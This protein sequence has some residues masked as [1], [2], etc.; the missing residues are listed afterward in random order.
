M[1]ELLPI[2][3]F[4]LLY[5]STKYFNWLFENVCAQEYAKHITFESYALKLVGVPF[6]KTIHI[7]D[8]VPA[9][10]FAIL[11]TTPPT[12]LLLLYVKQVAIGFFVMIYVMQVSRS[13]ASYLAVEYAAK[14]PDQISGQTHF[15]SGLF[16]AIQRS[17]ILQLAIPCIAL[18]IM[19]PSFYS[20]GAL[21][22]FAFMLLSSFFSSF[23]YPIY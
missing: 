23:K 17:V 18:T 15:K 7:L 21:G 12:S 22:G 9:A 5:L 16:W 2:A 1:N 8:I 13:F 11:Y 6:Y 3:Y 10:S 19:T 4:A 14:Y 20:Y